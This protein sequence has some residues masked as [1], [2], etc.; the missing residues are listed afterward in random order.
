MTYAVS[1]VNSAVATPVNADFSPDLGLLAEHCRWLL[2]N[3]CDGLAIL[4]TTGEANSFSVAERQAIV[5]GVLKA[6]IAP[7]R[8]LPGT[9]VA[10]GPDTVALT[11]HALANGVNRV[12]M[13]PPFYYKGMSDEG[14]FAAYARVIEQI[15]D[16]RLR[17]I[18]Y[19]IPQ[20][21]GVP[22][23]YGL[24]GRLIEAFPGIVVG[25]KDSSGDKANLV[26]MVKAFP[27]FAVISG[28]DQLFLELL[29]AGGAGCITGASNLIPDVLRTIYDNW[30]TDPAKATAAQAKAAE[31]RNLTMT[32]PQIPALK[33]LIG[34]RTGNAGWRR[35]RPPFVALTDA[36]VADIAPKAAALRAG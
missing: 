6:G 20:Q 17:V 33:A 22:L 16:D 35:M 28:P 2:D 21:S 29:Q 36:Q 26:G 30:Q 23:T 4:G 25:I 18:L 31:W 13:L 12:V 24:I 10:A 32:V 15:G 11:K 8:L 19:H 34:E 3:G 9:G 5:E 27:G 14:L 7:E 1:G